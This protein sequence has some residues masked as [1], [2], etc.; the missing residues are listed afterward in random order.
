MSNSNVIIGNHCIGEE[1]PPFIIAEAG[2]NHEGDVGKA[3]EMVD[4]AAAV[5]ADCIKFQ[6]HITEA[7]MVETDMSPGNISAEPLWD[8]IKRC[9]LTEKEEREVQARCVE[10]GILFLSTP[11]SREAS[12]RLETM[13]VHAYKIGSGECNN[14]PLIEHI[15]KKGKPIILSTGMNDLQS[16]RQSVAIIREFNVPLIL[17]HCTSIYPTPYNRVRLGAI[18][19]LRQAFDVPVGLSDHSIGIYTCFG[20][21]A[22]G[23]SVLE[24]HFTISREWPGP[25]ISLSITPDELEELV[26]GA[27][28]IFEAR[29]GSKSVLDE[30]QP[31]IDFAYA[32][33]CTIRDVKKSDVISLD[34]VW[35]KRPGTGEIHASKLKMVLGRKAAKDIPSGKHLTWKDIE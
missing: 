5:G 34:N 9:E 17:T 10:R 35:V 25:D 28:S 11:F 3:L 1:S 29:G 32:S 23:A 2:I 33:V 31:V 30:E 19:E 18:T 15:A 6:C 13:G 24:K 26:K 12:D 20:A 4:A 21:V 22:L 7:E 14:L 27:R 8:I 16:V